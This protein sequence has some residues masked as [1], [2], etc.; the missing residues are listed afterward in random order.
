[1]AQPLRRSAIF[2]RRAWGPI[3]KPAVWDKPLDNASTNLG[4]MGVF[5]LCL[6]VS[7]RVSRT[8]Y[9]VAGFTLMLLKYG[10]EASVIWTFTSS[11]LTPWHFLNPL[12]SV[13]NEHLQAAPEWLAVGLLIWSLPFLWI[14]TSMS[15]RRAADAG[16][17]AWLGL[18]VLIPIV[19]LIFMIVMCFIPSYR[20]AQQS[21]KPQP[22]N[23]NRRAYSAAIAVATSLLVG[24]TMLVCS[25]YFFASYGASLFF[26][27]PFLMSAVAAYLYNRPH[28]R[29][30]LES[31]M[32]GIASVFFAGVAVLLFALEGVICIAMVL[33]LFLPLGALGGL[34]GKVI[35]DTTTQQT[36]GL[37][38]AIVCLP[39]ICCAESQLFRSP[40]YEVMTA[41]EIDA[42]PEVVW[43]NV[44]NFPDLPKAAPWYFRLGIACPRRAHIEGQGV[45]AIRYCEFTTGTFV[46]PITVW[47]EPNQLAFDV[48]DQPAPMFE[49]SPYR[50]VHP[51]HLEG[52]LRSNRGQFL[53]IRRG[54]GGTRLEGRT[55]YEFDMFPQSYWTLW[56]DGLI[57]RIHQRV[58]SHIKQLSEAESQSHSKPFRS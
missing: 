29:G 22:I 20:E 19:N 42:P 1:M 53:L 49:R 54:D 26:G 17:S 4:L 32:V 25:V 30:Y 38:A 15:V 12:I 28:P 2:L 50:H 33:P 13:R 31:L 7:A 6:G 36:Q 27:T 56:S 58:L 5:R 14:A 24:A 37:L 39:L 21:I 57:H 46:E 47:D 45:G 9:A 10:V 55:W 43:K 51:P 52:Y 35:A 48:T 16:I 8:A 44:V 40:E 11:F 41:V 3:N 34:I 23:S 18:L